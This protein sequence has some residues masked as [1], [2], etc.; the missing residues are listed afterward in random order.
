MYYRG[1]WTGWKERH[2]D[3]SLSLT[4]E[5]FGAL[6][7]SY[8]VPDRACSCEIGQHTQGRLVW[9]NPPGRGMGGCWNI[10]AKPDLASLKN[11]Y[12]CKRLKTVPNQYSNL[13]GMAG[14]RK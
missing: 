8:S 10:Q 7:E 11:E 4:R 2:C 13:E 9:E 5:G 12:R 14:S 1:Q 6:W 3:S